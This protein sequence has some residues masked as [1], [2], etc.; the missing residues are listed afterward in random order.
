MSHAIRTR[1]VNKVIALL[2]KLNGNVLTWWRQVHAG[3]VDSEEWAAGDDL[4]NLG[5]LAILWRL[6]TIPVFVSGP[7]SRADPRHVRNRRPTNNSNS[8]AMA[9]VRR[10]HGLTGFEGG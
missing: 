1:S 7:S 8:R 6:T 10:L 4:R 3:L 9:A 5:S 2:K